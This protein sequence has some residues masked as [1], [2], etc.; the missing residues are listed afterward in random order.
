MC[1]SNLFQP[2]FAFNFIR[3]IKHICACKNDPNLLNL[4][5]GTCGEGK[6]ENS[7]LVTGSPSPLPSD[8]GSPP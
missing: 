5:L 8:C 2:K 7:N 1:Q 4:Q 6:Q 3:R